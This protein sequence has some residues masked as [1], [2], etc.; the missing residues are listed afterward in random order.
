MAAARANRLPAVWLALGGVL[1][2]AGFLGLDRW[3]YTQVSLR[4]ETPALGDRDFYALTWPL[5]WLVRG[6]FAHVVGLGVIGVALLVWQPQRW[7]RTV[8]VFALVAATALLANVLQAAIG[9]LRPNRADTH[10]AFVAPFSQLWTRQ[11]VCF[12]SGEAAMA[13]ALA[14]ALTHLYPRGR[15]WWYLAAT[16]AATARLVNG[17]HYPSD[18]AAGAAL[19]WAMTTFLTRGRRSL[20]A[21]THTEDGA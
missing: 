11:E 18:V 10:L 21:A 16:L 5:W 12:P 14:A 8:C 4:L 17:A 7:K 9:R 1:V 19:G 3:F 15:R 20:I 2:L 13:F 6:A